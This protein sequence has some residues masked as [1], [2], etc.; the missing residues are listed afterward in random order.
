MVIIKTIS[1]KLLT[2]ILTFLIYVFY[3]SV[4][5]LT[6]MYTC[7]QLSILYYKLRCI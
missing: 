5:K 2:S 7:Y 1:L 4:E 6:L 3:H